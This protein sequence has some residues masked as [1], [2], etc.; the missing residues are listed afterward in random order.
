MSRVCASKRATGAIKI[1]NQPV[2]KT[3]ILCNSLNDN[4]H[5]PHP[6]DSDQFRAFQVRYFTTMAGL[7]TEGGWVGIDL[8]GDRSKTV[9][10]DGELRSTHIDLPGKKMFVLCCQNVGSEGVRLVS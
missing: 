9:L 6:T 10:Q 1:G 5:T 3:F 7:I 2:V 4:L 8:G